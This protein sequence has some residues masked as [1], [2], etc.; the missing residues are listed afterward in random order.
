MDHQRLPL[1]RPDAGAFSSQVLTKA[2]SA[3]AWGVQTPCMDQHA[4]GHYYPNLADLLLSLNCRYPSLF[5]SS[6]DM[7]LSDIPRQTYAE[8]L[9]RPGTW[10]PGMRLLLL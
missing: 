9:L 5:T 2:D 8:G 10:K 7:P 1:A 3:C 6:G 4:P